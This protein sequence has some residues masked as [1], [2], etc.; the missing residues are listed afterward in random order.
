M[1]SYLTTLNLAMFLREDAPVCSENETDRQ[2]VVVVA[3][4]KHSGFYAKIISSMNWI[5][6]YIMC[7]VQSRRLE[8]CGNPWIENTRHRIPE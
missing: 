8:S 1:L 3:A 6:H 7:I 2:V 4:W 5:T